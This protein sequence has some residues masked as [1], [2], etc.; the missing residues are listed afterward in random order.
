MNMTLYKD[1]SVDYNA[2]FFALVRTG[3]QIRTKDGELFLY[4]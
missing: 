2:T 3:L 1:G 4:S